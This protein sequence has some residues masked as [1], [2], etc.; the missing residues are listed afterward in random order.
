VRQV[1]ARRVEAIDRV[2]MLKAGFPGRWMYR[3]ARGGCP[4]C[5]KGSVFMSPMRL[6]DAGVSHAAIFTLVNGSVARNAI[7]ARFQMLAFYEKGDYILHNWSR[8]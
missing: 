8:Q 2:P 6:T 7:A 3:S 4:T 5:G 1:H